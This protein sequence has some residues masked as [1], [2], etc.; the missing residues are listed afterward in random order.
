MCMSFSPYLCFLSLF[1]S[2][3]LYF[4]VC[5]FVILSCFS[6]SF[7][8]LFSLMSCFVAFLS[9][10]FFFYFALFRSCLST[11]FHHCSVL[12][13]YS[14]LTFSFY[15]RFNFSSCLRFIFLFSSQFFFSYIYFPSTSFLHVPLLPYSD[16]YI[17]SNFS[18]YPS[19]LSIFSPPDSTFSLTFQS[20]LSHSLSSFNLSAASSLF[21]F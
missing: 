1:F 3:V 2:S 17:S 12:P 7:T 11:S 14:H 10:Y 9:S 4:S 18:S 6:S 20:L 5:F 19:F 8:Y 21:L 15:M 16:T 13:I